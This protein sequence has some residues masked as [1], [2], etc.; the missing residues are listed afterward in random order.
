MPLPS[1]TKEIIADTIRDSIKYIITSLKDIIKAIPI[2]F[3]QD[4]NNNIGIKYNN[5]FIYIIVFM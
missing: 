4:V 1:R 2:K 5:F 3:V